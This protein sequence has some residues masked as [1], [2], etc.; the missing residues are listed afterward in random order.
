MALATRK[1]PNAIAAA[2]SGA[3]D[4][5][6]LLARHQEQVRDAEQHRQKQQ[7]GGRIRR[8]PKARTGDNEE[9]AADPRR[10]RIVAAIEIAADPDGDE[11]RQDREGR[12]DDAEPDHRQIKFDRPIGRG[13]THQREHRLDDHRVEQQRNE[14]PVVDVIGLAAG[15]EPR[16]RSQYDSRQQVRHA[17]ATLFV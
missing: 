4:A 2:R 1:L 15:V 17:T 10:L 6:H 11:D 7:S 9:P 3:A 14:Q 13:H 12:R 16:A 8:Q 5:Q